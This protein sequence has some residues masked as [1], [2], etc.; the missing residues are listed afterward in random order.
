MAS[1][2]N[3]INSGIHPTFCKLKHFDLCDTNAINLNLLA[4][5][6]LLLED[7]ERQLNG[8]V[9]PKFLQVLKTQIAYLSGRTAVVPPVGNTIKFL[10][11]LTT[12]S[13]VEIKDQ[14]RTFRTGI[15]TRLKATL[16]V[17]CRSFLTEKKKTKLVVVDK[18]SSLFFELQ[19]LLTVLETGERKVLADSVQIDYFTSSRDF[20][21]LTLC[22]AVAIEPVCVYQNGDLLVQT[23]SGRLCTFAE[24]FDKPILVL[25]D[26]SKFSMKLAIRK[27]DS[28]LQ[29]LDG[30]KVHK[31]F[32]DEGSYS[33]TEYL[34]FAIFGNHSD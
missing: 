6:E 20:E 24:A 17:F 16:L 30:K 19:K 33:M 2:K 12:E 5:F 28:H 9:G 14:L 13:F 1:E 31:V 34:K 11:S 8:Q 4:A 10:K 3:K 23:E 18:K 25:T 27:K 32:T 7:Y 22:S 21:Q 26:R 15:R 29:V